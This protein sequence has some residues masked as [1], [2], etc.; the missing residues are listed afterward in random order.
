MRPRPRRDDRGETLIELLVAIMI[1]ST[2]VV[3]VVGATATAIH[4]SDVHRKQAR[5]GAYLRT[6]A[7]TIETAVARSPTTGYVS[8]AVPANYAA[9]LPSIPP[10]QASVTAV[11][12]WTAAGTFVSTSPTCSPDTDDIGV[13]RV[14]LR[15][16][17]G[18]EVTEKLD[19]VIRRPCRPG[20]TDASC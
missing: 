17:L 3:A 12:R 5:A 19:I 10:Y 6:A 1:M 13:Q 20:E 16:Q 15:V 14:S 18:T 2:A 8:C 11:A 4:L 7:E 9:L